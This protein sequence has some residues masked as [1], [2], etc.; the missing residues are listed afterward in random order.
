[1]N[2]VMY[3]LIFWHITC[4]K[5]GLSFY[6]GVDTKFWSDVGGVFELGVEYEACFYNVSTIN[7]EIKYKV[8]LEICDSSSWSGS[9]TD[10][11][12]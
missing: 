6:I 3:F 5:F 12:N 11:N 2:G 4:D 1:M 7:N 9:G 8:G 10:D